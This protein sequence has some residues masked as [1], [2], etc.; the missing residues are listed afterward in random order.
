MKPTFFGGHNWQPMS[1]NP[2]TGLVYI[3]AQEVLG[4]YTEARPGLQGVA[5]PREFNVG[6]DFNVFAAFERV[7]PR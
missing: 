5:G 6:T 2:D 1:F 4:A 7:L 3:P